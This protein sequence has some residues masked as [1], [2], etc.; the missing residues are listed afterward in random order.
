MHVR[1][2]Y[3]K[4]FLPLNH[5]YRFYITPYNDLNTPVQVGNNSNVGTGGWTSYSVTFPRAYK[6]PPLL[7]ILPTTSF[8]S[9][10]IMINWVSET[11]FGYSIYTPTTTFTYGTY[12]QAIGI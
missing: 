5:Y 2:L 8:A 11:G 3:L 10:N 1:Y 6:R 7:S 4:L 9:E 12:W